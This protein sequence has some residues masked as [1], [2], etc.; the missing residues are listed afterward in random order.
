MA[1]GQ[2]QDK[3]MTTLNA[4]HDL[5][6]SSAPFGVRPLSP[7]LGAEITGLDLGQPVSPAV[8]KQLYAA[9]LRYQVLLFPPIPMPAW[10]FVTLYGLLE[11]GL[12]ISGSQSSVAHFAHL[13]GM[14]GGLLLI[15][16]WRFMAT[17]AS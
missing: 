1:S 17:R 2:H 6:S 5:S 14:A 10:L 15:L 7:H 11:L 16:W 12:G 13:G 3:P 4:M 8:F 9:F